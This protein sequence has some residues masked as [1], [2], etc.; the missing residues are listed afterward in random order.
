MGAYHLLPQKDA[1]PKARAE[2]R[3]ALAHDESLAEAHTA[4][5]AV[6]AI[7]DHDWTEAERC[8][9]RA[10]ELN[11]NYA[12]ARIWY[13]WCVLLPMKRLDE[14]E[15]QAKLAQESDPVSSVGLATV[16]LVHQAKR[17]YDKAIEVHRQAL[18]LEPDHP[19]A[20]A[21]IADAYLAVGRTD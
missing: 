5:G 8:F 14:A 16:G 18:E 10:M 3:A 4:L 7:Y 17:Q 9:N 19:L 11:P 12:T 2:A 13:T 6:S 20:I 21:C 15:E 1:M